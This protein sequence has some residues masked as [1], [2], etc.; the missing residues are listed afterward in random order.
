MDA[1]AIGLSLVTVPW[2]WAHALFGGWGKGYTLEKSAPTGKSVRVV[3]PARNEAGNIG[4]C[5][6]ALLTDSAVTEVVVVDDQSTDGTAAEATAA[7]A[8]NARL[9]VIE[10]PDRPAGWAGKPWAVCVGAAGAT[11]DYL[12]FVD[13]DV[14]V[15]PGA[16][17]AAVSRAIRDQA[18]LLS[19]YGTWELGSFW[20]RVLIPAFGW[21]I[22][23][24]VDLNRANAEGPLSL[25]FANGQFILVNRETYE[26][27]GGHRVVAAEVLDDVRLAAAARGA[28]VRRRMLWAP[29]AFRVRLYRSFGE[30]VAGY[31][32][33]LYEGMG[34]RRWL[35]AVAA[36]TTAATTAAVP[37]AAGILWAVG[38]PAD[39]VWAA[40]ITLA[41]IGLRARIEVRDGRS[42]AYA[43]FHP[44]AG[45]VIAAVLLLSMWP[46]ASWKG[47]SFVQGKSA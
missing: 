16:V 22:R 36:V 28:G 10:A 19:L 3:V 8:G 42:P 32:K 9:R 35:G 4:G 29:W 30:I 38:R 44:L 2:I 21:F 43:V 18:G 20:E 12:L 46:R 40:A 6:R 25:P 27:W 31:R 41:M 24:S 14:N 13:A 11:T 5:V 1:V 26:R 45:G 34:R 47:R 7:A 33:N 15:A 17:S 37:L 23:S 39:A